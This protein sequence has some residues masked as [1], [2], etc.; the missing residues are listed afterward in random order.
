MQAESEK[1]SGGF[2]GNIS[3]VAMVKSL[4]IYQRKFLPIF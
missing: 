4:L 1:K 3:S 2:A